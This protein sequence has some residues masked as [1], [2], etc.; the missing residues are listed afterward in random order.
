M[1][2]YYP[3]KSLINLMSKRLVSLVGGYVWDLASAEA[4]FSAKTK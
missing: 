2:S 3:I 1:K 4:I